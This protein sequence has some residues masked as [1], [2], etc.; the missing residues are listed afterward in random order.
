[1]NYSVDEKNFKILG[2]TLMLDNVRYL[3]YS[4]SYIE[5]EFIGEKVEAVIWTNGANGD[6]I[7]KAWIAVFINDEET[8]S[9]RFALNHEEAKYVLYEGDGTKATK[10][11][12]MKMSEVAFAK[13]GIKSINIE[14]KQP[15]PTNYLPRKIEFI[16]DSITCGY[17]NEGIFN[18]DVFNTTQENPWEAYAI[19]TARKL[20]ADYHLVSWSGIGIISNWVEASV[21]EPLDNWLMPMLYQYTDA[22]LC[23]ELNITDVEVWDNTR[24]SP[25][26]IVI[27][28]G[29]N[30]MSYT[31]NIKERVDKFGNEYYKFL[32]FVRSHNPGSSII[33]TLGAMGDDL[34]PEI[35]KQVH[36]FSD[37]KN[38]T[39][40]YFMKFDVQMD[41]D[42]IGA[43]WHPSIITHEKMA[44]KLSDTIKEIKNW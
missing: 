41:E 32:E 26:V 7:Y 43:D 2:R 24:F 11:R 5:F 13:V 25:D 21:N 30:D 12:I 37:D 4:G 35:E 39:N 22:H 28:L 31:R 8:P 33:C 23:K 16:G 38:D 18:V 42:G 9:K 1:M 15:E 17:G 20:G 34:C 44:Q 19:K 27:N 6:D 29:T 40:V 36:R 14:G 3:N 10:I